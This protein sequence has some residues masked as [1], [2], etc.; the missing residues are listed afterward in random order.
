MTYAPFRDLQGISLNKEETSG[1]GLDKEMLLN[2]DIEEMTRK[3]EPGSS[4]GK[5][6]P[7][8]LY[9]V[10]PPSVSDA[11]IPKT[12]KLIGKIQGSLSFLSDALETD[13]EIERESIMN[14]FVESIFQLTFFPT[15]SKEFKDAIFLIHTVT[16]AHKED[17]YKRKEILAL[18]K[19]LNLLRQNLY[20]GD[21][22]LDK[23]VEFLEKAGFDVNAPIGE[24]ELIL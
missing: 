9:K 15:K 1:N 16:E 11:E 7:Q 12:I 24:I 13:D 2:L 22:S 18:Q 14:S 10:H 21:E 6:S 19:T 4:G 17:I 8:A 20:V 5:I 23:C 3:T